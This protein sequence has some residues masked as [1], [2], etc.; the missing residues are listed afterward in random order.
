MV[1]LTRF[2]LTILVFCT[3]IG[4]VTERSSVKGVLDQ[5]K[6][7]IKKTLTDKDR[8]LED[9]YRKALDRLT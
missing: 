9:S 6:I 2:V 1:I 5:C 4:L 3:G 8:A 7:K